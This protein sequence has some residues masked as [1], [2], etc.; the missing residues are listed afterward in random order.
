[1]LIK[2]KEYLEIKANTTQEG[3]KEN[4]I[5]GAVPEYYKIAELLGY[6]QKYDFDQ[7]C[8]KPIINI[9]YKKSH[10]KFEFWWDLRN[11]NFIM[12]NILPAIY[13]SGYMDEH[14]KELILRSDSKNLM[15]YLNERI[16]N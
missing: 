11:W 10:R 7:W 4:P 5:I 8:E 6:V 2:E 1:M 9:I 14:I 15:R 16:S 13:E 12:E 3:T